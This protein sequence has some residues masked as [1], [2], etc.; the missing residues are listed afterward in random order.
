MSCLCRW[1]HGKKKEKIYKENS[2]DAVS[3]IKEEKELKQPSRLE[4]VEQLDNSV[5]IAD[6]RIPF[7]LKVRSQYTETKLS[8]T[9]STTLKNTNT[10]GVAGE[11]TIQVN[12]DSVK[13]RGRVIKP[14][15][16]NTFEIYEDAD[17]DEEADVT[18]GIAI[19][20][21][22]SIF[23]ISYLKS[24]RTTD[25]IMKDLSEETF[26]KVPFLLVT[27]CH[28]TQG[29]E[30]FRFCDY[31]MFIDVDEENLSLTLLNWND[32]KMTKY[33][34]IFKRINGKFKH[35][36]KDEILPAITIGRSTSCVMAVKKN[37]IS[38]IH[39]TVEC[40]NNEILVKSFVAK[41]AALSNGLWRSCT[42]YRQFSLGSTILYRKRKYW[43]QNT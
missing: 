6:L 35:H 39:I 24:T 18:F 11:D 30:I 27:E 31:A 8:T 16:G 22:K 29:H 3:I 25:Q 40:V 34:K 28:F 26:D 1:L 21:R 38:K 19:L 33:T 4:A 15:T 10:S 5:Q 12:Y 42:D 13:Y 43:V 2:S 36:S 17:G 20:I 32:I 9:Q 23:D 41:E 14:S 7:V 37:F